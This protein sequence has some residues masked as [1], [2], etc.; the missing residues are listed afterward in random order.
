MS[1]NIVKIADTEGKVNCRRMKKLLKTGETGVKAWNAWRTENGT[2]QLWIKRFKLNGLD[3]SGIDFRNCRLENGTIKRTD[4]QDAL[5]DESQIINVS[6]QDSCLNNTNFENASLQRVR[7]IDTELRCANFYHAKIGF[8]WKMHWTHQSRVARFS[9]FEEVSMTGINMQYANLDNVSFEKCDISNS[10][11]ENSRWDG[12]NNLTNCGLT[13][14]IFAGTEFVLTRFTNCKLTHSSFTQAK[15]VK[16]SWNS[17]ALIINNSGLDNTNWDKFK[18]VIRIMDS[19][20]QNAC[21]DSTELTHKGSSFININWNNTSFTNVNW[22]DIRIEDSTIT[23]PDF[24]GAHLQNVRFKDNKS[25]TNMKLANTQF[26]SC[27]FKDNEDCDLES[28]IIAQAMT[29]NGI[30][31]TGKKTSIPPKQGVNNTNGTGQTKEG[32]EAEG[33]TEGISSAANLKF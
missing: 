32:I 28:S 27:V 4:L 17:P 12:V 31:V 11:F 18:G 22:N 13:H 2:P 29:S 20:M 23:S 15:T 3:I 1:K 9:S 21:L 19:S 10:R 5:F 14:S 33:S 8:V 16:D 7:L 6:F 24:T 26:K 25:L 30:L